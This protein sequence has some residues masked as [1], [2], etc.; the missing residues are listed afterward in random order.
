MFKRFAHPLLAITCAAALQAQQSQNMAQSARPPT[1]LSAPT[2]EISSQPPL[3]LEQCVVMALDKNFD[4]RIQRTTTENALNTLEIAKAEYDPTL[5]GSAEQSYRRSDLYGTGAATGSHGLAATA[6]V[7]QKIIT[8]ATLKLGY[9]ASRASASGI[10]A[11]GT[12]SATYNPNWGSG[13]TL[14]VS[15][16]VLK[17]FGSA[18]NRASQEIAR[19]GI[20]RANYDLKNVV[21]S[22]IRAVETSYYNLA[23]VRAVLEVR[24]FSLEVAQKLLEE[25]K[26][27]RTTGVATNL[28]VLQ[29]EV[30]VATAQRDILVAQKNVNDAEDTLLALINPFQFDAAIGPLA[31]TDIGDINVSFD[32]S[33]KL[34]LDN[35]PDLASQRLLI[36]QNEINVDVA[37]NNRLPELDVYA[38]AGYNAARDNYGT[39]FGNTLSQDHHNWAIGA[40]ITYPWGSRRERAQLA[41]ARASLDNSRISYEKYDQGVLVMVRTAVRDVLTSDEGVRITSLATKLSEQQY[42]LE[43]ARYDQGLSTFRRVQDM[44]VDLDNARIAELNA[45]VNLRNALAE[46][47]RLEASSLNRYS[48]KLD[49]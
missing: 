8:G 25:N 41:Q 47:A 4:L 18:A 19:L 11:S 39:A 45:N 27:R 6:A 21:L 16:P 40:T 15:Q 44:K 49:N 32:R 24:K 10:A 37:K 38:N 34:A 5:T 14:S 3:T 17:N 13:L 12:A 29:A 1:N 48:V 22:T 46:L 31:I 42:E 9:T 33:Y 23:Y 7:S 2:G 35:A 30:G 36:K 20:D 43:K 28:D 26:L